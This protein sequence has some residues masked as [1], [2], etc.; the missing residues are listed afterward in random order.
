MAMATESEQRKALVLR[1][2]ALVGARVIYD[3]SGILA[4][5]CG[6]HKLDG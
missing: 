3:T 2:K 5:G 1:T 6:E 4:V